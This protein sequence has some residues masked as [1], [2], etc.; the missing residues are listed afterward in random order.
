M[1]H[2]PATDILL[3]DSDQGQHSLGRQPPDCVV[4]EGD[5][6]SVQNTVKYPGIIR[7]ETLQ[8]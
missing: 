6:C 4:N 7:M 1:E 8:M 2:S 5:V 3:Q